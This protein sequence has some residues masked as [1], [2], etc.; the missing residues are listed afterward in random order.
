MGI[1]SLFPQK[2][3][4]TRTDSRHTN[5]WLIIYNVS[6]QYTVDRLEMDGA[7]LDKFAIYD[8]YDYYYYDY[9][10]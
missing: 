10:Y 4:L 2:Q 9:Y 6:K 8:Y 1:D 3:K 7:K 5:T